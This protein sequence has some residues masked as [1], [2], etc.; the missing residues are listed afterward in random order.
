MRCKMLGKLVLGAA[1][2]LGLMGSAVAQEIGELMGKADAIWSQRGDLAKLKESMELYQ[3]VLAQDSINVEALWKLSRACWWLGTHSPEEEKLAIFEKGMDYGKRAVL[4]K[5]DCAP[6]HYWLGVNY[7]VYGEVKGVLKSLSLV[8]PI[9]EEMNKV[10]QLDPGFM[11]GGAYRIL[12]RMA[13]KLPWFAGGSKKESVEYLKKALEYGPNSFLTRLFLAETYLAMD[14]KELAKKELEW[15][16]NAPE[17]ADPGDKEDRRKA[18]K[19]Y[20]ENFR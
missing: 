18:Q 16:L 10:I 5:E 13:Y 3:K 1:L 4:L 15:C 19:L 12:G 9:K 11:H 20:Q 6:C 2:V 8:E 7:G 17:P 14:E